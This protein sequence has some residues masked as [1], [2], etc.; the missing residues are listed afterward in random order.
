VIHAIPELE[1]RSPDIALSHEASVGMISR[2]ELA[3]LMA[4]GLTEDSAR[5]LIIQGFL[6]IPLADLPPFLQNTVRA[7]IARARSGEAV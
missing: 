1:G 6:E 2:E 5:A 7:L 3:Y 4:S